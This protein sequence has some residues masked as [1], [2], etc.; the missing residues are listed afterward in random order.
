M[1]TNFNVVQ[2]SSD[3]ISLKIQKEGTASFTV[4][5]LAAPGNSSA[6]ATIP[7]GYSSNQLLFQVGANGASV[8]GVVLPWTSNDG[9]VTLYAYLDSTNLYIV[10]VNN[11]AAGTAPARNITA[12]YKILIP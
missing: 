7:H 2:M 9:R 3:S 1:I 5:A 12:G 6:T 4:P 10:G 11:I 8:D